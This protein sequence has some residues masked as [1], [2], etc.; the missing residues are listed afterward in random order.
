MKIGIDIQSITSRPTGIG[1]YTQRLIEKYSALNDIEFV[2]YKNEKKEELNTLERVCWENILLKSKAKKDAVDI[3]HIPGFAGPAKRGK[4]K[5]VTTVHDLIG[6]IYPQNLSPISRFY[7][8]RWLPLCVKKSDFII[9][10]SQNTKNDI[11]KFINFPAEKIKVIYL[12]ADERFKPV[13]KSDT[14]RNILDKYNIA[15]KYILNVGTIEPRKNIPNLISAFAVYL[16]E[17]CAADLSLVIAGKKSW[18]YPQCFS[19]VQE[20]NLK[21]KIIFCDYTSDEDLIALYNFAEVF[22]YPSFYEGFGLPV[23]EAMSCSAAVI[24]SENSSLPEIAGDAAILVNPNDT[25]EIK[26]AIKKVLSGPDVKNTMSEK[27]VRQA[28]KFSWKKTAQETIEVYKK[29]CA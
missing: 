11:I 26:N 29:L 17:T 21:E 13:E 4:Y 3:L 27:S 5:R 23:L 1:Y 7:W 22:I 2:Y 28:G 18:G 10:D 20:L 25:Q 16:K 8:Q 14:N 15:K 9:A 6:M 19:K 24:C 12:A